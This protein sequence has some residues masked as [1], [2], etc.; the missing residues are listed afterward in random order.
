MHEN[1]DSKQFLICRQHRQQAQASPVNT[2]LICPHA[3]VPENTTR[4][5]A[6]PSHLA[7]TWYTGAVSYARNAMGIVHYARLMVLVCSFAT[8]IGRLLCFG[9]T[10]SKPAFKAEAICGSGRFVVRAGKIDPRT[11]AVATASIVQERREVIAKAAEHRWI[12]AAGA[13]T[14]FQFGNPLRLTKTST[15]IN[16]E[17][18]DFYRTS[19]GEVTPPGICP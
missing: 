7:E 2:V 13:E 5:R 9:A 3:D 10:T 8:F 11:P 4:G 18:Y 17:F 1:T 6:L 19:R 14:S 15:A 12:E 16:R